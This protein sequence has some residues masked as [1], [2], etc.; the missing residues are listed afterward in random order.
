MNL[1]RFQLDESDA[2]AFV[3]GEPLPTDRLARLRH[4]MRADPSIAAGLE[5]MRADREA[6]GTLTPVRAPADLLSRVEA[7]L[8]RQSLLDAG[9]LN[10]HAAALLE[11]AVDSIPI[12]SLQPSRRGPIATVLASPWSRRV[13]LAA[14]GALVVGGGLLIARSLAPQRPAQPLADRTTDRSAPRTDN[15]EPRVIADGRTGPRSAGPGTAP[16]T[17][18]TPADTVPATANPAVASHDP[19]SAPMI[20]DG[21]PAAPAPMALD[22][23]LRLARQGRLAVRIAARQPEQALARLESMRH[24][25]PTT[26]AAVERLPADQ[27][28]QAI[29]TLQRQYDAMVLALQTQRS[30]RPGEAGEPPTVAAGD[31]SA[32]GAARPPA[33]PAAGAPVIVPDRPLYVEDVYAARV[34]LDEPG[35]RALLRAVALSS[36]AA[37]FIALDLPVEA[38]PALDPE[39]VLWWRAPAAAWLPRA[40]VPVVVERAR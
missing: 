18:P 3:E 29:A 16:A 22:E 31:R 5:A 34:Q 12:S 21:A 26:G 40:V 32:P 33:A 19:P 15:V 1:E 14:G 7:T 20:A 11:P 2:L 27:A 37:E 25:R 9:T 36:D 6:L 30:T 35:L 4:A 17:P 39:S 13:A 10:G 23:A 28:G 8:E 38:P 24:R